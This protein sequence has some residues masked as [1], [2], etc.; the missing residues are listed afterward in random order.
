MD[1]K[2]SFRGRE[3]SRCQIVH[4]V[5]MAYYTVI[6]YPCPSRL[7]DILYCYLLPMP[8]PTDWYIILLY[9]THAHSDWL[10]YYTVIYYPCCPSRLTDILCCYI[11][12]MPIPTD[13]YTILL[14][15]THAHP[16]SLLYNMIVT[17]PFARC[18]AN[19]TKTFLPIFS[20]GL[21]P[22]TRRIWDLTFFDVVENVIILGP[23]SPEFACS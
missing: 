17:Y 8:I 4:P 14:Y 9:I 5:S 20:A 18:L 7:T 11:L 22:P 10:I 13:W 6:Y 12:P 23:C 1:V 3:S 16:D 21:K 15:I 19:L 2:G